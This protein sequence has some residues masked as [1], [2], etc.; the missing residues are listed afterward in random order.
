MYFS[1]TKIGS[2]LFFWHDKLFVNI[3]FVSATIFYG[4]EED[5]RIKFLRVKSSF[6][7]DCKLK[8]IF[9]FLP[10]LNFI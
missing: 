5:Q 10:D 8:Y 1:S 7:N 4:E 6:R 9:L 3:Y 2:Y